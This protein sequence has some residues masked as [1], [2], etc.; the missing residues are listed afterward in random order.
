MHI[1][2]HFPP[3]TIIY[4]EPTIPP[5]LNKEPCKETL[6]IR[7]LYIHHQITEINIADLET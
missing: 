7:I 3:Y 6:A 2:I 4:K 5:K 1:S